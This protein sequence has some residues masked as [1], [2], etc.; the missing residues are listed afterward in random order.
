MSKGV[1]LKVAGPLVIAEGMRDANLFDVVRVSKHKLIGEI[2]E[3]HGDA[4]SIQ[5]Y[6][7]TS[8]L[9]PGEP[10]VST[11]SP[12][13]VEL[14]PGLI[15]NIYDGIQRPL[16]DIMKACGTN[17]QRGV[18]VSSLNREKKWKFTPTVSAGDR[19]EPGDIIGTVEETPVVLHK[20]MVPP[21]VK[22]EVKTID[23]GEFTVDE[24]VCVL[25]LDNGEEK[26][27]S[28][29]QKWPVRVGR[30]YKKKL[31]PETPLVTGQRVIDTLF[32]IAKGGVAAVPGPFGSGKTVVQHQLAKWAEADIVVY[33]GCGERGNEMTDVLNEFPEL[34]D[35]KTGKSL[36]ERTVL[37]ANTSDMPVAA[38]EAS[39]Y[40]G[41]TIAEYFRDM[42][43]SVA[44]MADSTSRWA[45][46]LREMSGRLE[47][48][49]GEEGYPAYLGSRLAQFYERA[50]KVEVLG[51]ND[52][53]GSLSVIGAVSPPGGDISE[54]VSQA[55]LRI[56]KV[57]WGLD[58]SLA[59][60]RH[61]PALNWLT[62]YSLYTDVLSRWFDTN[63]SEDW[64]RMR[65]RLMQ[66][67]QDESELEE[68]VKLVGMDALS[69]S[70]R[71]KLEAA[72]S[73]RED[74][75]H[76]NAFH[77]VD[78][79][80]PLEKQLL[81]MKLILTYYDKANDALNKG[82]DIEQVVSMPIR[83]SIGRFKYVPND[84]IHSTFDEINNTLEK[85]I[86]DIIA[87][88]ED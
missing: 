3:M 43:Y 11:G 67:L 71:L 68:I 42:G 63:V 47:E 83:E 6:E 52:T 76:Q 74:Y 62:S 31:P 64:M 87:K 26:N 69:P 85:D 32:P 88:G 75:L 36:M 22:G 58:S 9:A 77:D 27:L 60:K 48:M 39:I 49:P 50:G 24:T 5:V 7:E 40:T 66:L 20:I 53:I 12:L 59:Y 44:L 73:I 16:E 28:L 2:I 84:N 45:E 46:A 21:S 15:S 51:S 35:P 72:R 13:S 23:S 55:T 19:V 80:T 10:V 82:A 54:P 30:P 79:Y 29:M 56:V 1:I 4:A 8:G 34:I 18:E 57:F 70:D 81:M 65:T 33:I 38:R 78:T 41:I 37:I 14:G 61:F 25:K 17:L 86:N